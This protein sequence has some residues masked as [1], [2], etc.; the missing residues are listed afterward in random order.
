MAKAKPMNN[1]IATTEN[2][3]LE[4][5]LIAGLYQSISW[6]TLW[7]LAGFFIYKNQFHIFLIY[8][9][10]LVARAVFKLVLLYLN[11]YVLNLGNHSKTN[12]L[13]SLYFSKEWNL[14]IGCHYNF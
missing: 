13:I 1:E 11:M 8:G 14:I 2:G 5:I 10:K 12:W 7:S 6:P 3:I 9:S 4:A